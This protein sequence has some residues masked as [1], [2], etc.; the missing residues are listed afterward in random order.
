VQHPVHF[1]RASDGVTIAYGTT[2]GGRP[3]LLVPGWISHVEMD[4]EDPNYAG[5]V[6]ALSQGGRRRIIRLDMRGTGLSDRETNDTSVYSR[7]RDIAAVIDHMGLE[8]VAVFAWS[9]GGPAAIVYAAEHPEKVSHL[10]LHGSLA[11]S[12]EGGREALGRAL[13]DLIRADWRI[14]SR[15]IIE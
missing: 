10:I 2:G 9:M 3:L 13:V 7:A 15:A 6:E 5:F 12:S 11:H 1:A 4:L 14:G 8:S